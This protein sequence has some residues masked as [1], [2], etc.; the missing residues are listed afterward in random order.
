MAIRDEVNLA[1]LKRDRGRRLTLEEELELARRRDQGDHS[2]RQELI[3]RNIPLAVHVARR[4]SRRWPHRL[5]DLVGV[6]LT[7]L[8]R[9]ADQFRA[10][11]GARFGTVAYRVIL[12]DLMQ[13]TDRNAHPF[14][15]R[16]GTGTNSALAP[17]VTFRGDLIALVV[18]AGNTPKDDQEHAR[19]HVALALAKL[20]PRG[21]EVI[22]LRFG[23]EGEPLTQSEVGQRLGVTRNRV[24]Q[25]ET[26]A[27]RTLRYHLTNVE[28][29]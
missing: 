2:A 3:R 23:F 12:R 22:R 24:S 17:R 4:V 16:T 21:A 10:G 9:A 26:Q 25:I 29:P 7:A 19:H 15:V 8:C 28:G 11:L 14:R 20:P 6:A 13:D 1:D 5:D 27:T 18:A